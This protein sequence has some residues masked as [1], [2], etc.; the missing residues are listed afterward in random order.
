MVQ[1]PNIQ[2]L[3]SW[4]LHCHLLQP[5]YRDQSEGTQ[6]TICQAPLCKSLRWWSTSLIIQQIRP[7][8]HPQLHSTTMHNPWHVLKAA[9]C[10]SFCF[11]RDANIPD[12]CF[13]VGDKLTT[14]VTCKPAKFLG[15]IIGHCPLQ[16][17]KAT[18]QKLRD[19][20][21]TMMTRMPWRIWA[22]RNMDLARFSIYITCL[23]HI[24]L[25]PVCCI[26]TA[27]YI[28]SSLCIY[29]LVNLLYIH[30]HTHTPSYTPCQAIPWHVSTLVNLSLGPRPK[31][32]ESV[33]E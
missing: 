26:P 5:L 21:S 2:P 7:S 18:A 29:I 11:S 25:C 8:I 17:R 13:N 19:E 16:T 32:F 27:D 1:L 3:C 12:Q 22:H 23:Y 10:L 15:R 4:S 14:N 28:L 33:V 9:K 31:L 30:T 24:C 20:A 6:G